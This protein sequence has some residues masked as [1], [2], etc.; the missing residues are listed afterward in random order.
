MVI[1]DV[2][3]LS[4]SFGGVQALRKVS[5]NLN[6]GEIL[7]LIG[8]NGSGKTTLF[9]LISGVI[10]SDEGKVTFKGADITNAKPHQVCQS[11]ITR[12]FQIVRPFNQLTT[13]RNVMVGRAYGGSPARNL[14]QARSESLEILSYIGLGGKESAPAHSLTLSGRKRLELGR[15]LATKPQVLLLDEMM[16][17][18][19]PTEIEE[20]MHL[21][22]RVRDSGI[23]LIVV[24]HV[25]RAVMGISDRIMV[26]NVGEKIAEGTPQ[27]IGS[28]NLVI[29]A[30]L[31]DEA[32]H[33]HA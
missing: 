12:T 19:N 27:E 23:T 22:K 1:L 24:E 11:G 8:P 17:G 10:K 5:F 33:T 21:V 6:Q 7:G 31:G 18:L 13:L 30:Y 3:G 25:M 29:A 2:E 15:A 9:N 16:A 4:R 14:E 20:A 32:G 26:L 28:N